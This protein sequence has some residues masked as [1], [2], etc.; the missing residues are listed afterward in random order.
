[1]YFT[2]TNS[3]KSTAEWP[4][5]HPFHLILNIAVG[6]NWGGE[7]GIDTSIW[8]QRMEIDYA[9]IFDKKPES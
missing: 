2:F 6:G 1:V 7:K 9:R 3:D 8:P 4:F 5:D